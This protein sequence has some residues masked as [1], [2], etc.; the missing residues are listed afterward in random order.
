MPVPAAFTHQPRLL[1]LNIHDEPGITFGDLAPGITLWPLFIDPANATWVMYARY[2]PGVQLARHFHTGV[3]HFFTVKGRWGY[4][5][6]PADEQRAGSYLFEPANSLHTF[7]IPDDA[8]EAVEGF[9][10][11]TGANVNFDAEGNYIGTDHAGSMEALILDA[12]KAQ[13]IDLPRYIRPGA[14]VGFTI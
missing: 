2:E 14:A 4:A 6:H 11:V 5:E 7:T 1:S 10:V 12:A 3:V 13:G 8:T 9:M